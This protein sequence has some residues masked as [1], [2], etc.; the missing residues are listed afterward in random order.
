MKRSGGGRVKP[1]SDPSSERQPAAPSVNGLLGRGPVHGFVLVALVLAVVGLAMPGRFRL[2]CQEDGPIEW[3]T[4][5]LFIVS[6]VLSA[7]GALARGSSP[8]DRF[9]FSLLALFTVFVA[10]EEISWGQRLFTYQPPKVFL[11]QNFQQE[12][13]LHNLLKGVFDS[14]WQVLLIAVGYG[15]LTP[16]A[17]RR[18][19]SLRKLSP[20][21]S[22]IPLALIVALI[23]LAY[24]TELVGECAE[25]LLGLYFLADLLIR[26]SRDLNE[27]ATKFW[28]ISALIGVCG[29]LTPP[30]LDRFVYAVDPTRHATAVAE[31]EE[32]ASQL[33]DG[34]AQRALFSKRRVHKRVYTAT[35]RGY[36]KF[37]PVDG[38]DERSRFLLDPWNQPYWIVTYTEAG[39]GL[40]V[41]LYSFGPNRRRD[42]TLEKADLRGESPFKGDDLAI[43]VHLDR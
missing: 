16:L 9:A 20:A 15:V 2:L 12:S 31:L 36:C 41:F 24:P 13:N 8:V 18:I 14:R 42:S 32:L 17:A 22:L 23:E 33:S 1:R 7:S 37:K 29:F 34:G 39:G 10:G 30:F 21:A 11:E 26:R 28:S 3:A 27:K 25:L 6:T 35:K 19:R 43:S 38:A 40:T 5:Y 4:F